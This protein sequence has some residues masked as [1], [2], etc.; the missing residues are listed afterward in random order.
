MQHDIFLSYAREDLPRVKPVVEGLERQGL[1]SVDQHHEI[2]LRRLN[3]EASYIRGRFGSKE[4]HLDHQ[5]LRGVSRKRAEPSRKGPPYAVF[6]IIAGSRHVQIQKEGFRSEPPSA[7]VE[8]KPNQV[9]LVTV[10]LIALPSQLVVQSA[11]AGTRVSL[12]RFAVRKHPQ[13]HSLGAKERAA[14]SRPSSP[15]LHSS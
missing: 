9:A 1:L 2:G 4:K 14:L 10:N 8:V 3:T 13:P 7:K 11:I 15:D 12:G 5:R 6:N